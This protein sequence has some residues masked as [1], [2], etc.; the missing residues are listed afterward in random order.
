MTYKNTILSLV[1]IAAF[2]FAVWATLLTYRPENVTISQN[3]SLPDAFMEDVTALI[4]DKEGNPKMKIVTS[5]M[6]HYT[7]MDTTNL[8]S[9]QLTLYR[10]SP[11]PWFVTSQKAKAINGIEQVDF[12]DDVT[13]HHPPD[14][15]NPSTLI[16]T[17]SLTVHP[18]EET[19]DTDEFITL[20]QPNL[21]VKATGMHADM[22]TGDI[23]LLSEA[24]GEY[25]PS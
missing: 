22:K 6:V 2:G 21:T 20:I 14:E 10:K 7:E 19:A 17:T 9:P 13:I 11:T 15:S 3:N 16:K 23:K 8:T 5:K 12:Y 1:M 25:A 4:M 24:R 18:N